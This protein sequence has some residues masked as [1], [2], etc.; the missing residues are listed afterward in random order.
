MTEP[1]TEM[2]TSQRVL[3]VDCGNSETSLGLFEDGVLQATWTM[4]TPRQLTE[5]EALAIL[6]SALRNMDL[7]LPSRGGSDGLLGKGASVTATAFGEGDARSGDVLGM[8]LPDDSV[9]SCVVPDLTSAWQLSLKR[10]CGRRTLTVGPGIKTGI[11]MRYR[12]PAEV[13][14]DRMADLASALD[15]HIPPFVVVDMGTTT[16]FEV[17]DEEGVFV[18]GIIAPG[19]EL[20]ARS[21]AREAAKL[22]VIEVAAPKS[23][24]GTCTRE[25]MQSGVV[26]GEVAR[27]DGLLDMIDGETGQTHAVIVTGRSAGAVAAIL[28]HDAVADETLTLRGLARLH[29]INRK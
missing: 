25:A 8:P 10:L 1:E 16:N 14:S 28:S 27:I 18:G 19:M 29:A 20:G 12:D 4:I 5:D 21:L 26:M 15:E 24:V 11:R 17:V 3:A 23:V 2:R 9:L 22:P 13:G 6:R 7:P